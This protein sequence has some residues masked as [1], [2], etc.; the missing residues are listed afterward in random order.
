MGRDSYE[1]LE[2]HK[3]NPILTDI[4]T[5]GRALRTYLDGNLVSQAW[6]VHLFS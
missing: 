5:V 2:F 6:R 4:H 3:I 1:N